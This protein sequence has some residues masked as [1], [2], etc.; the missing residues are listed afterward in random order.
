MLAL[1]GPCRVDGVGGG[2]GYEDLR[3]LDGVDV[4]TL[5]ED[6][7]S[8]ALTT[9]LEL[10]RDDLRRA[11]RAA[12][13]A[14]WAPLG[15]HAPEPKFACCSWWPEL[16]LPSVEVSEPETG[17]RAGAKR[18]A[19]FRAEEEKDEKKKRASAEPTRVRRAGLALARRAVRGRGSGRDGGLRVTL[20]ERAAGR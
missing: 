12:N 17:S 6:V 14:A 13:D 9:A 3:G 11:S 15:L 1:L 7:S 18:R 16:V 5:H 19:E 10:V 4:Q 20:Y 8:R 2:V